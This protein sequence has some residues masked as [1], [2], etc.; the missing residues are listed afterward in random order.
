MLIVTKG[1]SMNLA[2]FRYSR[3]PD[4]IFTSYDITVMA[5]AR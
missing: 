2:I 1:F 5:L 4:E 3:K